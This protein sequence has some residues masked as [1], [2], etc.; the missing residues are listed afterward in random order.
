MDYKIRYTFKELSF[1]GAYMTDII[2]DFEHKV[3]E[4]VMSYLITDKQFEDN[5][6]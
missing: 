3:S 2:K 6:V 1:W 5:N 4:K